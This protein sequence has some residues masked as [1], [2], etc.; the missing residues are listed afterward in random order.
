[1]A[2]S[3]APPTPKRR[4]S[5][6]PVLQDDV[7]EAIETALM[8]ELAGVGYGRLSI[9]AVARRAGVGKAAI[10]RRWRDKQE[11]VVDVASRIA[12]AAMSIPDTG[13]LRGDVRQFLVNG[14]ASLNHP[15]ADTIIPDLLAEA[16]RNPG[17][18]DSLLGAIHDPKRAAAT[19]MLQRAVDR[20]ELPGDTDLEMGLGL[21]AG[22]M[23]VQMVV[24]K[25]PTDD[26]YFDR[27]TE[28]I[29]CALRA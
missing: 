27:L 19:K 18:A 22:P 1:M 4:T 29:V 8:A 14:C 28:K 12:L 24:I 15:L 13:S 16:G 5:G 2:R 21:L 20:N 3:D 25:E 6:G 10:Y 26:D 7:T 11:M 17:L 9:D 23:Y